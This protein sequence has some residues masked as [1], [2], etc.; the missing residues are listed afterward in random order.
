MKFGIMLGY[1]CYSSVR[2]D[3]DH[4][5]LSVVLACSLMANSLDVHCWQESALYT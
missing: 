2:S 3:N 1:M 4:H 5:I